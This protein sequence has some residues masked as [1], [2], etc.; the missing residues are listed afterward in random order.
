MSSIVE[1][2]GES[3]VILFKAPFRKDL[4]SPALIKRVLGVQEVKVYRSRG[5]H[6]TDIETLLSGY[7]VAIA[8]A[9]PGR[10]WAR[11]VHCTH[12][13]ITVPGIKFNALAGLTFDTHIVAGFHVS[14]ESVS[15]LSSL[16][17]H[18]SKALRVRDE[19]K[20]VSMSVMIAMDRMRDLEG[21]EPSAL[22]PNSDAL[23]ELKDTY[24]VEQIT[25]L[26]QRVIAWV[27]KYSWVQD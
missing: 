16:L 8:E 13:F 10:P 11:P 15:T 6:S 26:R 4:P 14:A 5:E 27:D 17:Y 20:K 2:F 7:A 18:F 24:A 12:A 3:T 9:D 23:L 19:V 21:R 22:F 25:E 1:K